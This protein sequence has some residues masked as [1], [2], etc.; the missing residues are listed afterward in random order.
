MHIVSL[1]LQCLTVKHRR[2]H[3]ASSDS[4]FFG[5]RLLVSIV[6]EPFGF[7][8]ASQPSIF[9]RFLVILLELVGD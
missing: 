1:G 4:K 6:S 9:I 7:R 3:F 8:I 2:S 5:L